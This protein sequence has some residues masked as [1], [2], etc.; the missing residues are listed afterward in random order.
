MKTLSKSKLLAFR[1]C[2]KRLWLEV[3]EPEA[4]VDSATSQA[5]FAT[6]HLVG[7]IARSVYDP[8]ASGRVLDVKALG[9]SG[10]LRQTQELLPQ[11]RPIFEAGFQTTAPG[12]ALAISDVLLPIDE[13]AGDTWRMVEVK[14][15]TEVKDYHLDD[16][17]IQHHVAS[18]AGVRLSGIS[19]AH[20]DSTWVYT[21]GG[22]YQGLLVE[23]DL[24]AQSV[25]RADEVAGWIEQA[26]TVVASSVAPSS[27]LGKHCSKPFACGFHAFCTEQDTAANGAIEHP[28][29]LLP[30]VQ[31]KA[32]VRHLE[33]SEVRSLKDVPDLLLNPVQLR[34]KQQTLAD[35][36]YFDAVSAAQ[37]LDHFGLTGLFLDFETI[38]PAVPVWAGTRPYQQIPFQFSLHRLLA[39]GHLTHTGFLDLS[40]NDPS[41]PFVNSL[42]AACA[43]DEPIYVYN[44]GFEGARIRELAN[45][46]QN[47]APGLNAIDQRLV[48]L[49]PITQKFYY[50]PV[51]RGSWSIKVVLPAI[52]PELN[53]QM[54]EGV[55]DGLGAQVAYG[56]AVNPETSQDRKEEIYKQ[57]WRYCRMDTFATVRLWQIL[58]GN[59]GVGGVNDSAASLPC[60]NLGSL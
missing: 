22:D 39:S 14:S 4:R 44:K 57:L 58:S 47:L 27:P 54:L 40:G 36:V 31:A 33:R 45:R 24:T 38:A 18:Q 50:H 60:P 28:V 8:D 41:I 53:Y 56:E 32:L 59:P 46:W 21:G 25:A 7:D 1:Q 12:G 55:Q 29:G 2:P 6:G 26:H 13:G 34:V 42:I 49:L 17:A 37:A 5:A 16:A 30:R 23:E 48:D 35:I 11:R 3:Y 15:S 43:G 20:I 52:A 10:L 9:V 51:Q 19:L